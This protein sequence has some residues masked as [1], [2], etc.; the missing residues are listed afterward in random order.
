M[1][2]MDRRS[3]DAMSKSTIGST[4]LLMWRLCMLV[5]AERLMDGE[6]IIISMLYFDVLFKYTLHLF[7]F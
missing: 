6:I 2:N 1:R 4:H 3:K 5:V 7:N